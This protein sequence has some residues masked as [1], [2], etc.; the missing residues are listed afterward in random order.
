MSKKLLLC[1]L[2]ALAILSSCKH[3]KDDVSIFSSDELTISAS[4]G[5]MSAN[6]SLKLGT[7][8]DAGDEISVY[9]W[10]G[11]ADV[12]PTELQVN[13]SINTLQDDGTWIAD[14]RMLWK[15]GTSKHYFI[16]V[17]P[18]RALADFTADEYVLNTAD[19]EAS[20][21]LVARNL[22]GIS[23]RVTPVPLTFTH[24][25]SRLDVNI[26]VV[27]FS[28]EPTEAV[29]KVNGKTNATINYLTKT[30][31]AKGDNSDI[32]LQ[33]V[34]TA[35]GYILSYNSI[36]VPQ[37]G[38]NEIVVE[39][40][41]QTFTYTHSKDFTLKSG[42]Y[43]TV[44]LTLKRSEITLG[45]V[46]IV[47]WNNEEVIDAVVGEGVA[48]NGN[49]GVENGH[50]WVDLGLSVKWATMNVGATA[51]QEYGDYYAWGETETK[52]A[53]TLRNYKFLGEFI[54]DGKMSLDIEDDAAANN[55]GGDW[56]MPTDDD[57]REMKENCTGEWIAINGVYGKKYTGTNGNSIFLPAAGYLEGNELKFE[58]MSCLYWEPVIIRGNYS[59]RAE[60]VVIN[61]YS[62]LILPDRCCGL[63]VRPVII[64]KG[65]T[66]GHET[67]DLGLPSGKLWADCNVGA[68]TPEA[69][70]AYF[71]WGETKAKNT[72]DW[73][74]YKWVESGKSH[75]YYINKYSYD[76]YVFG[77]WHKNVKY[78]GADNKIIL[79]SVDDVA[80]QLWGDNWRMPT[81][82]EYQELI[83]NSTQT[84]TDSYEGSGVTGIIIT[85]KKNGNH[86]FM[87]IAGCRTYTNGGV[88]PLHDHLGLYW[89]SSLGKNIYN[90]YRTSFYF[91]FGV[92]VRILEEYQIR[93]DGLSIRPVCDTK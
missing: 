52:N 21:I 44:N 22:E 90:D 20:D 36:M 80:T 76:D 12:V 74:T 55:W 75:W 77:G 70:G 68:S 37:T 50:E 73:S 78:S 30:V 13:N 24:I 56:R 86:I 34:A 1:S 46:D 88:E 40:D 54:G 93:E 19:Q 47:D 60:C 33:K 84:L 31:T 89:T 82:I 14:P 6:K 49:R 66:N 64:A 32:A 10:T 72:Y 11:S 57:W 62:G 38:I 69:S 29:V 65:E 17:Y 53:Y 43:T 2:S 3:D 35:D 91:E 87:P 7:S 67:I 48:N 59:F 42:Y 81:A 9:A 5:Q 23:C 58:N 63:S 61:N 45:N 39:V 15:D 51:P 83:D 26:N 18:Q 8:F 79:E 71:A 27:N 41:G 92:L 16:G 28:T 4:V 25:M 85:S